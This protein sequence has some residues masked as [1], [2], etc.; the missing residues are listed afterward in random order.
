MNGKGDAGVGNGCC[1]PLRFVIQFL[2]IYIN[3]FISAFLF[4]GATR[5]KGTVRNGR[6]SRTAHLPLNDTC[7]TV[8][9]SIVI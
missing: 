6:V 8:I 1:T 3:L 2:E 5:S 9:R 7:R 4:K